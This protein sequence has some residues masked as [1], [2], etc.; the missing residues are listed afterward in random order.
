MYINSLIFFL[1]D[2]PSI[3]TLYS[4]RFQADDCLPHET[5]W[6]PGGGL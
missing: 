1:Y 3:Y 6:I 4:Y 2:R 5:E